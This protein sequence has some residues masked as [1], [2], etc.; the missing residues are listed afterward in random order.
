MKLFIY[1]LLDCFKFFLLL[2]LLFFDIYWS[3]II[4]CYKVV[5]KK[6]VVVK[7]VVKIVVAEA[8]SE[9]Y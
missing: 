5:V 9:P 7:V 1:L 3:I 4:L 2:K 6:I 8:Y